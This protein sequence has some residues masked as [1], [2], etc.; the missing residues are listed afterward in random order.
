MLSSIHVG[1]LWDLFCLGTLVYT[2]RLTNTSECTISDLLLL[3]C[4]ARSVMNC[5]DAYDCGQS[6]R[7]HCS[8]LC[9]L[10]WPCATHDARMERYLDTKCRAHWNDKHCI[11][12]LPDPI[13][14][15]PVS[16]LFKEVEYFIYTL[17]AVWAFQMLAPFSCSRSCK[18]LVF[19]ACYVLMYHW[20]PVSCTERQ[21]I[22]A[23]DL[24]I[25]FKVLIAL[26]VSFHL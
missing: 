19:L 25:V 18:Q 4:S 7:N 14:H 22:Q 12:D 20:P 10:R 24:I 8:L 26:E 21:H 11:P 1:T 6:V 13:A 15:R 23:H 16:V 3:H 5:L 2:E 17:I 9:V